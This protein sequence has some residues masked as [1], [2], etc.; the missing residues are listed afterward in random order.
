MFRIYRF[1]RFFFPFIL[2][3][4]FYILSI[5]WIIFS[6]K[7]IKSI[8]Y[9]VE[10]LTHFQTLKGLFF[11]TVSALLIFFLSSILYNKILQYLYFNPITNLPN[12]N[13]LREF[14][15]KLGKNKNNQLIGLINIYIYNYN[16]IDLCLNQKLKDNLNL[17]YIKLLNH[18]IHS[19]HFKNVK[20]FQSND[21]YNTYILFYPLNNKQE[22]KDFIIKFQEEITS[23]KI[24]Y[25]LFKIGYTISYKISPTLIQETEFAIRQIINNNTQSICEFNINYKEFL[26]KKIKYYEYILAAIENNELSIYIQPKYNAL[27]NQII[28]GEALIRWKRNNEFISPMIFI[29]L[30]EESKSIHIVDLW[31]IKNILKIQQ[32]LFNK[33]KYISLSINLSPEEIENPIIFKDI[34]NIL[35]Q[36]YLIPIF[37]SNLLEFEITERTFFSNYEVVNKNLLKLKQKKIKIA[38]DDF[39]IG[40]SSLSLL[41]QLPID[42]IKIDKIFVSNL[43]ND[44]NKR[45]LVKNIIKFC[46]D[47]N[48]DV[49]AEGVETQKQKEILL[50][51]GCDKMQG[52]LFS[53]PLPLEEFFKKIESNF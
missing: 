4:S 25:F 22:I 45:I 39:G 33:N 43:E 49:I 23:Q 50:E 38:I 7:I 30:L 29:P 1:K 34:I 20:I 37:D 16:E 14:L 3:V 24:K 17:E 9:D 36:N 52:Y 2:S 53:V 41:P 5:F 46:K 48:Y 35:D 15:K 31:M 18:F 26:E 40:Y 13:F 8:S 6:D 12:T 21:N 32:E 51:L 47:L 19:Q 27:K 42:V 28:G 10:E 11:I 44:K